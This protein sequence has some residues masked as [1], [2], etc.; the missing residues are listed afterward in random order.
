[1]N[2]KLT[3]PEFPVQLLSAVQKNVDT[4][5]SLLNQALVTGP[6]GSPGP[7]GP[8]GSTIITAGGGNLIASAVVNSP[9]GTITF[10]NIP[11]TY[12]HLR[13]QTLFRIADP[14]VTSGVG[15]QVNNNT[16]SVNINAGHIFSVFNRDSFSHV[17]TFANL[18][19]APGSGVPTGIF[20]TANFNIFNYTETGVYRYPCYI[21]SHNVG[22]F[23]PGT[24]YHATVMVS[25]AVTLLP[26]TGITFFSTSGALFATGTA[27]KL[28]GF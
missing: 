27:V 7:T 19:T 16:A 25:I 12:N 10:A 22:F 9:T 6:T 5:F 20:A 24:G 2:F 18:M 4:Q 23:Y 26:L 13:L 11:Q 17:S 15:M 14:G 8:T 3:N 28:Y 21:Q 1:M